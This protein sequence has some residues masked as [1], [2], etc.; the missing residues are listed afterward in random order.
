[1]IFYLLDLIGINFILLANIIGR[2]SVFSFTVFSRFFSTRLK[3]KQI[4]IQMHRIGVE[5]S[6]IV[7]L[8]GISSGFALALQSYV[9]LSRFGGEVLL[10]IVVAMGITRELGPVLTGIIVTGRAGSAIAA[11]IGTMKI[12]E[13]IEALNTLC[14]DPYQYLFVPR[15]IASI[16]VLPLLT[17]FA[18]FCGITGGY[19]YSTYTLSLTS[20]TYFSTI[21]NYLE[22]S[23]ILGGLIKS[24]IF[25]LILSLT[26][27]YLGYNTQGGARGVGISTTKSVVIGSIM[28]LGANYFL[29]SFLF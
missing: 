25:G 11:E 21:R 26:G 22:I 7:F 18:M 10:G 27:C 6:I 28:I 1:M 8:T 15:V 16:I 4:F 23:D 5:S 20:E 24:S 9:G 2:F 17:T 12:T 14:I 19:F 3:L 29:S 13:Q